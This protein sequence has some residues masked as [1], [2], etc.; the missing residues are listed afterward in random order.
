MNDFR[1]TIDPKWE[2]I[3]ITGKLEYPKDNLG[4]TSEDSEGLAEYR[5]SLNEAIEVAA[6]MQY[7]NDKSLDDLEK[8][9]ISYNPDY[10]PG[11]HEALSCYLCGLGIDP[12]ARGNIT[13]NVKKLVQA[14]EVNVVRWQ[15][16]GANVA[17]HWTKTMANLQKDMDL[18]PKKLIAY[19]LAKVI[20]EILIYVL[21]WLIKILDP[22][23]IVGPPL[24]DI[25][26]VW[27]AKLKGR[28]S[29]DIANYVDAK[30]LYSVDELNTYKTLVCPLHI[31]GFDGIMNLADRTVSDAISSYFD[32]KLVENQTI[33]QIETTANIYPELSVNNLT[34]IKNT[35]YAD[36]RIK[37]L[38]KKKIDY[39]EDDDVEGKIAQNKSKI[40]TKIQKQ[41][42]EKANILGPLSKII[43]PMANK[44]KDMMGETTKSLWSYCK[45][46]MQ[47]LY[48]Y[49][50]DPQQF[51]CLV[52]S[53]IIINKIKTSNLKYKNKEDYVQKK[54][55][56]QKS[57]ANDTAK[58][59]YL[60]N[61]INKE[62]I[63]PISKIR[64]ILIACRSLLYPRESSNIVA[65]FFNGIISIVNQCIADTIAALS[66]I[67]EN[68][69]M[70]QLDLIIGDENALQQ[71]I[72]D[73]NNRLLF[74][75][76]QGLKGTKEY[77][78]ILKEIKEQQKNLDRMKLINNM[79]SGK[80]MDVSVNSEG[81]IDK[82]TFAKL[83][84]DTDD[85]HNTA[86]L[87]A[88]IRKEKCPPFVTFQGFLHIMIQ[89]FLE[90]LFSFVLSLRLKYFKQREKAIEKQKRNGVLITI[91][92][93][94]NLCNVIL[95]VWDNYKDCYKIEEF[96]P[97]INFKGTPEPPSS[98]L[99]DRVLNALQNT[100]EQRAFLVKVLESM[101]YSAEIIQ[102]ILGQKGECACDQV[103]SENV[104]VELE[105]L[106]NS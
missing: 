85:W 77:A 34:N 39:N 33:E 103:I 49:L 84:L 60:K 95:A 53:L 87:L 68:K 58:I 22:V 48:H 64:I 105:K 7:L 42:T 62:I 23:P 18:F 76:R 27:V 52:S 78:D 92:I 20:V 17:D 14:V 79:V 67:V 5:D 81:L 40:I 28:I 63:T 106:F 82:E 101:G 47:Q 16:Y 45:E 26:K 38:K 12:A 72:V 57:V 54:E 66:P 8:Y 46:Y 59:E 97:N 69:I 19:M 96:Y 35:K 15:A 93:L 31:H 11:I 74:L 56:L 3:D 104:I 10:Y 86:L 41:R 29:P 21:E 98:T 65:D 73:N 99:Y 89:K 90:K 36:D 55:E 30:Q 9:N 37:E 1:E 100:P 88:A 70:E 44:I 50:L 71:S 25:F 80:P 102:N 13:I 4:T 2:P 94:I 61:N 75:D 32:N 83:Q 51:C 6:F 24:V 43:T 91:N